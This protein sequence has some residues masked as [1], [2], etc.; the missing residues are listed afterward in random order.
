LRA[1]LAYIFNGKCTIPDWR[2]GDARM[3]S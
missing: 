2:M 3:K 1:A